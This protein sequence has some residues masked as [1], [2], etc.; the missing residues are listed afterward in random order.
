MSLI[1]SADHDRR[2]LTGLTPV[3]LM[4][5]ARSREGDSVADVRARMKV[6]QRMQAL[7]SAA[8][9]KQIDHDDEN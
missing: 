1:R 8:L 4:L 2:D 6:R 7:Q 9:D 5:R 3:E